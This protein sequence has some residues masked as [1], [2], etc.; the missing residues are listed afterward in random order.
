MVL[1]QYSVVLTNDRTFIFLP[2]VSKASDVYPPF[3]GRGG[4]TSITELR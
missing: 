2:L 4:A 1:Q 3:H